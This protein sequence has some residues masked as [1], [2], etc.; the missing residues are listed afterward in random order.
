L[1]ETKV[2]P[3]S[4]WDESLKNYFQTP[5]GSTY[6][7]NGASDGHHF[8]K[9][10]GLNHGGRFE[11]SL[12][13]TD[14]D[15]KAAAAARTAPVAAKP[16][17]PI[18]SVSW[19]ESVPKID[20]DLGDWNMDRGAR[21]DGG[22]NRSAEVA[23][24]RDADT[25]YL[26]YRVHGSTLI[27]KGDN[28]QTL[29]ISGDC[30]DLMLA[31]DPHATSHRETAAAGDLRL[32]LGAIHDKPIAV[33]YR[34]V[35]P[36]GG[37]PIQ[38]MAARIDEI[39][40]LEDVQIRFRRSDNEYSIEAAVPLKDLVIDPKERAALRGDIGVIYADDT[41]ASRSQRLYY[42]NHKTNVTADLTTEATLE[43]G[44]W[45]LIQLP[46]GPNLLKDG[47]FESPL[48]ANVR[49]GWAITQRRAGGEATASVD[50]S[51]S[52]RHSLLLRQ[53]RPVEFSPESYHVPDYGQFVA[54]ANGSAGGGQVTVQQVVPI[55]G[56]HRYSLR[57]HYLA[58]GLKS[59]HKNPG[60]DRGYAAFSAWVYWG[61]GPPG[62]PL[63]AVWVTNDQ[64][65]TGNQWKQIVNE[66]ANY[67]SVL[68]PYVAPEGATTATVSLSL[69][70]NAAGP[71]PKV[72]VDDVELVDGSA[73]ER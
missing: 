39:R 26:A 15:V 33:L 32:L 51:H 34:P 49:E 1:E 64:T 60:P 2:G 9:I 14:A 28:W 24:G 22:K 8:L 54:S 36:G 57:I 67:W 37:N 19:L 47:G 29:F 44:Q 53:T 12:E 59:E 16:P 38:L 58:D 73:S 43:P 42:Y 70:T 6:L 17:S 41:G 65:D 46:L 66:Q 52:G 13:L 11:Q 62:V 3:A 27:N 25:L 72:W 48:A 21:L 55:I 63:P 61:G 45:G 69:T 35:V 71:Q 30:V 4:L 31:T 7:V 18:V 68:H 40:Q 23:L 20:G 10:T 50:L 56:G 5:D